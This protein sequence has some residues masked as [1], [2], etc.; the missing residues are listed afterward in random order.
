MT[1]CCVGAA[2]PNPRIGEESCP[3][4]CARGVSAILIV[5]GVSR[6][7]RTAARIPAFS[8]TLFS[9]ASRHFRMLA[10][11][12]LGILAALADALAVVRIPGTDFSTTPALSPRSIS[13]PT[14]EMPRRA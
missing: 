3:A 4:V 8:R 13:S 7:S 5:V 14:F 1:R 6:P 12:V 2:T 9:M 10:Q 11:V